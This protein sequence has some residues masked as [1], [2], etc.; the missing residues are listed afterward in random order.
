MKINQ[1]P[2]YLSSGFIVG[3]VILRIY[4]YQAGCICILIGA[5]S[6]FLYYMFKTF[7]DI[8][9]GRNN[10]FTTF[11]QIIVA[12]MSIVIYSKYT[13]QNFGNYF[14]LFVIPVFTIYA[15]IFWI[16]S[17]KHTVDLTWVSVLYFIFTIPMFFVFFNQ[18]PTENFYTYRYPLQYTKKHSLSENSNYQLCYVPN[19]INSEEAALLEK[20]AYELEKKGKYHDAVG[21]YNQAITIEPENAYLYYRLSLLYSSNKEYNLTISALDSAINIAPTITEYYNNRAT[22]YMNTKERELAIKDLNKVIQLDS[23]DAVA[24]MNLVFVYYNLYND[25]QKA[26]EAMEKVALHDPR[27]AK[28]YRILKRQIDYRMKLK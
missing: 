28:E 20:K 21:V 6:I 9:N 13:F 24:Y 22:A 1:A 23:T 4:A 18:S 26:A 27:L 14:G 16:K 11:F 17:T 19:I 15:I 3:G 8:K 12:L 2:V 25:M 10:K 5:L 7:K